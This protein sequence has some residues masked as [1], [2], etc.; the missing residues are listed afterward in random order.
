MRRISHSNIKAR[1]QR[2]SSVQSVEDLTEIRQN[3]TLSSN[4]ILHSRNHLVDSTTTKIYKTEPVKNKKNLQEGPNERLVQLSRLTN[5]RT[6]S[7]NRKNLTFRNKDIASAIDPP[8][9]DYFSTVYHNQLSPTSKSGVSSKAINDFSSPTGYSATGIYLKD[10]AHNINVAPK[11]NNRIGLIARPE[12]D[13]ISTVNKPRRIKSSRVLE[14]S[15][16]N[17]SQGYV[18]QEK[19]NNS[20]DI[21][22]QQTRNWYA[23]KSMSQPSHNKPTENQPQ[24]TSIK[25]VESQLKAFPSKSIDSSSKAAQKYVSLNKT[26]EASKFIDTYPSSQTIDDLSNL[27]TITNLNVTSEQEPQYSLETDLREKARYTVENV[28]QQT[29]NRMAKLNKVNIQNSANTVDDSIK[30]Y[31]NQQISV[32]KDNFLGQNTNNGIQPPPENQLLRQSPQQFRDLQNAKTTHQKQVQYSR[33]KSVRAT[34]STA[35]TSDI[36]TAHTSDAGAVENTSSY[37]PVRKM[38]Q[39][40]NEPLI[41]NNKQIAENV[42][43]YTTELQ[44]DVKRQTNANIISVQTDLSK[45]ANMLKTD[46]TQESQPL[47]KID[48]S[49]KPTI[50]S[51]SQSNFIL[52]KTNS[53]DHKLVSFNSQFKMEAESKAEPSHISVTKSGKVQQT[54]SAGLKHHGKESGSKTIKST[55]LAQPSSHSHHSGH[56]QLSTHARFHRGKVKL[57]DLQKSLL[58]LRHDDERAIRRSLVSDFR[59]RQSIGL[60]TLPSLHGDTIENVVL[61]HARTNGQLLHL[62]RQMPVNM[63]VK[64]KLR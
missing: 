11:L 31:D 13:R 56:S 52:G 21:S 9:R 49:S 8:K 15:L 6:S 29:S 2:S 18:V 1:G 37:R 47:S 55:I 62:I 41:N 33:S 5:T 53:K 48:N 25:S 22:Y 57:G 59:L 20:R 54:S 30:Q 24:A 12:R 27:G 60:F 38:T 14:K 35:H 28:L 23:S 63:K 61:A 16:V 64:R 45:S 50:I 3:G 32:Q 17:R 44:A 26:N 43:R 34:I 19:R 10:T 39:K 42:T 40:S 46:S 4:N 36:S 7:L 51:S 58:S